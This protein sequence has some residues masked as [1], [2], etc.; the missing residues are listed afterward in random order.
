MSN[1]FH[2]VV[3][4]DQARSASWDAEEVLDR[5]SEL[6]PGS[7]KRLQQMAERDREE[8][9]EI[10]RRRISDLS[11]FMRCLNEAIA[12]RANREDGRTGRFWEGRF[13]AQALVDEGALLTC[14]SYVDLNPIRAGVTSELEGDRF[15]SIYHRLRSTD[16]GRR[17]AGSAQTSRDADVAGASHTGWLMPFADESGPSRT[18][19]PR[20]PIERGDYIALLHGAAEAMRLT[21]SDANWCTGRP[22]PALQRFGLTEAGFLTAIRTFSRSFFTMAGH[23]QAILAIGRARGLRKIRGREAARLLYRSAA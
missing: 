3:F 11:W 7:R 17:K 20:L 1:H 22:S 5:W 9:I 13:R 19:F 8:Q 18:G 14:M 23:E 16:Y 10:W 12:R 2:L 21:V 6:F 4:I 15:T